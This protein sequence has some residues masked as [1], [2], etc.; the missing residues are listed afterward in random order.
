[1][2]RLKS[3]RTTRMG[4]FPKDTDDFPKDTDNFPKDTDERCHHL[5]SSGKRKWSPR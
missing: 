1:M 5:L 2:T 3:G 4:L